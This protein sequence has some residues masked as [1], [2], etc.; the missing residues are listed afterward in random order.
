MFDR[1]I[2]FA[3]R[4]A[5][6]LLPTKAVRRLRTERAR[7]RRPYRALRRRAAA[8]VGAD[9]LAHDL[10]AAGIVRG[11]VVVVHS[12]LSRI[13]DVEGG[14]ETVIRS[15]RDVLGPEGTLVM[16]T[17]SDA[18]TVF[19]DARDGRLVDL[20]SEPSLTGKVTEILR[21]TPGAV[22]SSHPFSSLC[23]VGTRAD[24]LTSG[25]D[26][27]RRIAHSASP[28]GRLHELGGKIVGLGVDAGPVSFYHVL[29]DTWAD[30][31]IDVYLEPEEI[32]YLDASGER[33]SRS[34]TRY[35]PDVRRTRIDQP[36][37]RW[38]RAQMAAH[39]RSLGLMCGF[40]FGQA[41]SWVIEAQP[42]YDELKALA[43][44]G[45]TIYSTA[46]EPAAQ[47]KLGAG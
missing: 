2:S 33:I 21:T 39:L 22:R 9:R 35:K 27:D 34:I 4:Q 41:P 36:G 14:A 29:E 46:D 30:F 23:A 20:R 16:P 19:R 43:A 1:L 25:H 45:V 5:K 12:S 3:K 37:S 32:T 38:L 7:L 11:D 42:L 26:L 15:L 10:A 28:L 47:R 18:D 40:N 31:P 13:G 24:Y 6:L 17:F 8:K 44:E